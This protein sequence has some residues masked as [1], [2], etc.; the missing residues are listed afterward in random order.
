M[1]CENI[2]DYRR[3]E[4]VAEDVVRGGSLFLIMA[5]PVAGRGGTPVD[6]FSREPKSL[7]DQMV[8]DAAKNGAGR[9]IVR[10]LGDPRFRGMDK[11][12]YGETSAGGLRSEVHYVVD[13][14]T[15]RSMDFKFKHHAEKYR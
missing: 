13:P 8:L 2:P 1:Y 12:S 3:L 6:K 5:G 4:L 9:P 15:G 14:K 11:Y 10:N 7:M